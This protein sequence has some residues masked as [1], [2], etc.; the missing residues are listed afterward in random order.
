MNPYTVTPYLREFDFGPA[1][2]PEDLT[3]Q[4]AALCA[5]ADPAEW[6]PEKGGSSQKAKAICRR[7]EVQGPCLRY[8]L[9]RDERFGIFGGA[10]ERDR[11]RLKARFGADIDAAVASMNTTPQPR[12]KAA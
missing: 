4:D 10:S 6:F 12:E 11:R 9:E 8:A 5:Q 1:Q 3:W 2:P 7:C